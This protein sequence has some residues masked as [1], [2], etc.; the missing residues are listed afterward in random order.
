MCLLFESQFF[1]ND[2]NPTHKCQLSLFNLVVYLRLAD[3]LFFA[4]NS[5]LLPIRFI[6]PHIPSGDDVKMVLRD[7]PLM[8]GANALIHFQNW[9]T[10][11]YSPAN[12]VCLYFSCQRG[13]SPGLRPSQM[14][15]V[16]L[17][18]PLDCRDI[19][20]NIGFPHG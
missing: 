20:P 5:L 8:L 18:I 14:L 15:V 17:R 4:T 2:K 6:A 9:N 1:A 19:P 12:A 13:H 3:I 16:D 11:T 10:A 7:E